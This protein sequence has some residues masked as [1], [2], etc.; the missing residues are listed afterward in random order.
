MYER[1]GIKNKETQK[2][3]LDLNSAE[4]IESTKSK[5]SPDYAREFRPKLRQIE[6]LEYQKYIGLKATT[7]LPNNIYIS[8]PVSRF[9]L[10]FSF[11]LK[12][13]RSAPN[14]LGSTGGNI[15][16]A[17]KNEFLFYPPFKKMK[18]RAEFG[19]NNR[20]GFT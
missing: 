3:Y 4:N 15:S 2:K 9:F 19:W 7:P 8:I 12:F 16:F 11:L 13:S 6:N 18:K 20:I 5:K 14:K 17:D 10:S 1:E